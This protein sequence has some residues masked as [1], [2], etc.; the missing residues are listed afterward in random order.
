MMML[1]SRDFWTKERNG[2]DEQKIKRWEMRILWML[3]PL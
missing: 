1:Q 3:V 2:V